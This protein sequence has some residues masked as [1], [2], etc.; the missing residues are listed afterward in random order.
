MVGAEASRRAGVGVLGGAEELG[1]GGLLDE[2]AVLH[3]GDAV[4]GAA[5]AWATTARSCEM[6]SMARECWCAQVG[7]QGEDLG[8]DGDVERGGGLVGDEQA[9]AVDERGWR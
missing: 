4:A 1:G 3:D 2:A 8:L 5:A 9:G 6:K 7:E